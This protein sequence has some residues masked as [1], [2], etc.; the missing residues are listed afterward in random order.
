MYAHGGPV[1]H[2][3]DALRAKMRE[4]RVD[5]SGRLQDGD[6][7]ATAWGCDL[8]YD[9]VK[10]NADYASTI[11]QKADGGVARDD[12]VANYSPAF[13]R[14]LL[15]EALKYISAFSGQRCV[16]KY[17]GAAMVKES[18]KAA[19]A[20]DVTL[21]KLVGLKPVVVHGG[22][23]EITKTLER[24]GERPSSWTTCGS[25]TPRASPSSR[26]CSPAR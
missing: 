19:F 22:A 25:P 23:P 4:P 17:G 2:D 6:A 9:Y 3:R 11:F 1:E 13:K 18:L 14:T 7:R 10:I 21:L 26:W 12:R 15:V 24:L 8:S 20:E 16:I 5:V